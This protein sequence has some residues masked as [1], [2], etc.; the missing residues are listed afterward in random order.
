MSESTSDRRQHPRV[1]VVSDAIV[2]VI[3]DDDGRRSGWAGGAGLNVAIDVARLGVRSAL[4]APIAAD[5]QGDVLRSVLHGEGVELIALPGPGRTGLAISR[6]RDGEPSYEFSPSMYRRHYVYDAA[7]AASIRRATV[8]VVNSFPMQDGVQCDALVDVVH[9]SDRLLVVDPNV[10]PALVHDR[11]AYRDGFLR[12]ARVASLVKLSTQDVDDLSMGPADAAV[13]R[14]IDLGAGVVVLT[15]AG[16]GARLVTAD[17]AVV[18]LGVPRRT[19]PVIDT[20]GAGDATL[21]RLVCELADGH[22]RRATDDWYA[23]LSEAMELAA[24]V[25]R[26]RGGS[27]APW[28]SLAVPVDGDPARR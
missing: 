6:R 20:M 16:H 11:T 28:E 19:E 18:D 5:G 8:V 9:G 4:A 27:L 26:R 24:D 13:A 10:R 22:Q 17:G 15:R 7:A 3:E 25:C 14:L 12:L 21:A 2:D 23:A 1:V